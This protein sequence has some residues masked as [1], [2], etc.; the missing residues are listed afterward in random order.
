MTDRPEAISTN[1]DLFVV[2]TSGG[3][4][5]RITSNPGFDGHPAY[6]PDGRFIAYHS[7]K[8]PE[9]ESDR[10]RLMLYDRASGN[11]HRSCRIVRSQR[12]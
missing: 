7:Q 2:P 4:A 8:T 6:S 10:W 11:A 3:E 1:G 12:G 5:K 9:Y